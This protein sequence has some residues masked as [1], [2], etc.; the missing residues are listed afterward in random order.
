MTY[1][2]NSTSIRHKPGPY[3]YERGTD[4]CDETWEIKAQPDQSYIASIHFWD[5]EDGRKG[6]QTEANAWLLAASP[7]MLAALKQIIEAFDGLNLTVESCPVFHAIRSARYA[8]AQAEGT[9]AFR[10][11]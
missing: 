9:L 2:T 10:A 6:K 8:V 4:G 11:C 1:T 3:F 7:D 5:D